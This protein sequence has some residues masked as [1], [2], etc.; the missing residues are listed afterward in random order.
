VTS[1]DK[2]RG[3]T[4]SGIPDHSATRLALGAALRRAWVGYQRRL[5]EQMSD[6][7]FGDR[8][9]PDGRVLRIC[10]RS[11]EATAS[12]IGREMGISR[13]GAAKI[14]GDLRSRG[15]VEVVASATSGR[16][17]TITLT[18]SALDYLATQR[19]AAEGIERQLR[20][21]IGAEGFESLERLLIALG[22]DDQ[23]RMSD[24]LRSAQ[25]A[26]WPANEPTP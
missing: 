14:I 10:S 4:A 3:E 6:A 25:N 1:G 24:Y 9:F 8:R 17:N 23:P 11:P 22:G 7:G 20:E 18:Q 13:Q 16:E 15:Y 19:K 21:E 12:Q 2:D 5:D 26:A